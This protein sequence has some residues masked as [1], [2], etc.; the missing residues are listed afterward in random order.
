M[1]RKK[2]KPDFT[3]DSL[4]QNPFTYSPEFIVKVREVEAEQEFVHRDSIKEG[5]LTKAPVKFKSPYVVEQQ[6]YTKIYRS[7]DLRKIEMGC[8]PRAVHLLRFI[9]YTINPGD[10]FIWINKDMYMSESDCTRNTYQG[11]ID[12]LMRYGL[13]YMTPYTDVYWINPQ[14]LFCGNR[15][16]KYPNNL[17]DSD[18]Q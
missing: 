10:D 6:I 7:K 9:E 12:E 17:K 2:I 18:Q 13:I 5:V 3:P 8:S 1:G 11:A 16:K 4:G 14:F 15:I